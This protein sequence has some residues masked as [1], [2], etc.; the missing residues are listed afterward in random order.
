MGTKCVGRCRTTAPTHSSN[1]FSRC[2]ASMVLGLLWEPEK[3]LM[4]STYA[5][6]SVRENCGLRLPLLKLRMLL[7]FDLR[8]NKE[9][10]QDKQAPD[11][12]TH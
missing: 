2:A 9:E 12:A 8:V 11:P 6:R 10:L 7:T 1:A 4:L 5:Y 3:S